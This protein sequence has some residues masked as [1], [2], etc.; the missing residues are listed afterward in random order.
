[1]REEEV[2]YR[3]HFDDTRS[4]NKTSKRGKCKQVQYAIELSVSIAIKKPK[5]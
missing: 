3:L 4:D 1:M 2:R 5:K